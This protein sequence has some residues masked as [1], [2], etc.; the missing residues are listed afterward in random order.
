MHGD[1]GGGGRKGACGGAGNCP[2][3]SG[4]G[5]TPTA[6]LSLNAL[7]LW[8]EYCL[9]DCERGRG[10]VGVR[11]CRCRTVLLVDRSERRRTEFIGKVT[12]L[13]R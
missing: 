2:S 6:D 1:G 13:F 8:V 4:S 7:G 5:R 12:C 10:I 11:N 3:A 9:R